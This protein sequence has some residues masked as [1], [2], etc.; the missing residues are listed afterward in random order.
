MMVRKEVL[1]GGD[2]CGDG[3]AYACTADPATTTA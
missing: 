2:D 1:L 3:E